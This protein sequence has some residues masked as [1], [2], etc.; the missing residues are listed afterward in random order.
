MVWKLRAETSDGLLRCET[1]HVGDI[2]SKLVVGEVGGL[3]SGNP[4][5]NME[6]C[7][8]DCGE[9]GTEEANSEGGLEKPAQCWPDVLIAGEESLTEEES[10]GGTVGE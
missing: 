10:I 4:V 1:A 2:G 5:S 9:L 8:V 6:L 7:R 3:M